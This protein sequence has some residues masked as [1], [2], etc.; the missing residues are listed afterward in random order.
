MSCPLPEGPGGTGG[1]AV[2][3]HRVAVVT[4]CTYG[5][6]HYGLNLVRSVR[7]TFSRP[8]A[9]TIVLVD[10]LEKP[11]PGAEGGPPVRFLG[12]KELVASGFEWLAGKLSAT[13]L[14]CALKPFAVSRLLGEGYDQVL[15]V[16][17]D[18]H[19]FREPESLLSL[20]ARHDFVVVPHSF[21]PFPVEDP[22]ARPSLGDLHAAG[23]MNAGLF[24]V[25]RSDG[26]DRFLKTW[27]GLTTG[28]GAFVKELGPQHEQASFNWVLAFADDVAVCRDPGINV[29]YWNLHERPLRWKALDGGPTDEWTVDGGPLGSFH[30]SGFTGEAGSLSHH[31]GR[32][33]RSLDVNVDA[34]CRFYLRRLD[35]AQRPWYSLHGYAFGSIGSQELTPG[36]RDVLKRLEKHAIP[37][38]GEWPA[39]VEMA[40]QKAH[41]VLSPAILVPE[42]LGEIYA[43]RPDLQALQGGD[44]LFPSTFLRWVNEWLPWEAP[45]GWLFERYAPFLFDRAR[46]SDLAA[47]LQSLCPEMSAPQAR[48]A[49][50]RDRPRAVSAFRSGPG[51]APL[52]DAVR[53]A[54]YRFP[55]Y[56]AVLALRLIHASRP[57]LQSAF[58]DPIGSDLVAFRE[59]IRSRLAVEYDVPDSAGAVLETLDPDRSL[60]RIV[61]F[62]R[63]NPSLQAQLARTG[64]DENL[65]LSL[66]PVASSDAGFGSSDLSLAHWWL[67]RPRNDAPTRPAAP[68][69]SPVSRVSRLWRLLAGIGRS[70][71]GR[72][73]A[74]GTPGATRPAPPSIGSARGDGLPSGVLDDVVFRDDGDARFVACLE[75]SLQR[76]EP[77]EGIERTSEERRG[78]AEAMA[79]AS[80]GLRADARPFPERWRE[81]VGEARAHGL[82]ER[83]A[84]LLE[85][86]PRGINVFGYFRSPIGL[87]T[88]TRG[89]ARAAE[90][91]GYRHRDVVLTN[92][93]M[94]GDLGLEDL[95]AGPELSFGRNLV[96]SY[97]H[98][99]CDVFDLHPAST[100]RGRENV[101]YLAWEQRD[102]HPEWAARLS[103]Y[104]RMFA[105]S[106]FAAESIARGTGRPCEPLPCVVDVDPR[107]ASGIDRASL[108]LPRDAFLAGLVFDASSAIERKNPLG[109]I[110]ALG[111]AFGGRK[112]IVV[113]LKVTNGAR[114]PFASAVDEATGLLR[115]SGLR[116]VLVTRLLTKHETLGLIGTLDLCVSLH[117][118]EGFGYTLAEAMALG[119]PALA[120]RYSGNLDF[121]S[122]DNSWLVSCREVLVRRAEGP[123]RLGTV[124]AEP[125]LDEAAG[126]MREV[127]ERPAEARRRALRA[128]ADVEA[129]LSPAAVARRLSFLLGDS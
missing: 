85:P 120:T 124:W 97:P 67:S 4:I 46:V 121:M 70:V 22:W 87:G 86:D 8:P 61:S 53:L 50:L 45:D 39:T 15:W 48:E 41:T 43:G 1:E 42:Y 60:A 29:A 71:E 82:P 117:R 2:R 3:D 119:V 17:A 98:I 54:S 79:F 96:V 76:R 33:P 103:R 122:D 74:N 34:L 56:D 10:G 105:L 62:V 26:A 113:V 99:Q 73:R 107:D 77:A 27:A 116:Y 40:L 21:S 32:H 127:L 109:A 58:P 14:C 66:L 92:T 19:F 123:F 108:G 9:V 93:T 11:R 64:I 126:K 31:D 18:I 110:R 69:G 129:M 106:R 5:Y 51:T 115:Q 65:L 20:G 118:S 35:E 44:V 23:I 30:F 37:T 125:D 94:D 95:V 38:S 13:E 112:D 49:I 7:E 81:A 52:A 28:P 68:A 101:A 55:A 111:M 100:F 90:L 72:D 80:R 57:D 75:R 88:A 6:L 83:E 89:L 91:A 128:R 36:A 102:L 84:G 63:L 114:R 47:A 12:A 16:D 104:D 24:S 25:R 78:V 59:W